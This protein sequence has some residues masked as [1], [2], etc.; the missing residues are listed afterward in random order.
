MTV[1]GIRKVL[2]GM[3]LGVAA[4]STSLA[5]PGETRAQGAQAPAA[6]SA[7]SPVVQVPGGSDEE[8]LKLVA[9]PVLDKARE[10]DAAAQHFLYLAFTRARGVAPDL[11]KAF[12]WAKLASD[13]GFPP[14]QVALGGFYQH[15][16]VVKKDLAKAAALYR[17]AV[18]KQEPVAQLRLAM[19]L[20]RGEGMPRDEG[21]AA[22]L[23]KAAAEKQVPLAAFMY[24]D[25][26]TAGRGVPEDRLAGLE[27]YHR[28]AD[29]GWALAAGKLATIYFGGEI[30]PKDKVAAAK[31][32]SVT[33]SVAGAKNP[34]VKELLQLMLPNM[35]PE[36]KK[37]GSQ[38]AQ[39]YMTSHQ[40]AFAKAM[41]LR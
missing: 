39:Q 3:L 22:K 5:A 19:M 7:P 35:T 27:W 1:S 11:P 23:M 2:A 15:G 41:A 37:A 25:M 6:G 34:V 8:I 36:E 33:V 40:E 14:G 10:G 17:Q 32:L 31:W 26:L 21:A 30:V 4:G 24:G 20:F 12:H 18:E 9:K 16:K 13:Q 29:W 28:A 38:Q